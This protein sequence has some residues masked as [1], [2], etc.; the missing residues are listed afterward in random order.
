M[1]IIP[2]IQQK[3][4]QHNVQISNTL[5]ILPHIVKA[6]PQKPKLTRKPRQIIAK[7]APVL[8]SQ[9]TPVI[10]STTE[11]GPIISP[12]TPILSSNA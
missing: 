9:N 2:F 6:L 4:A 7:D 1:K 10:A 12:N 8:E 3:L 5:S 11:S